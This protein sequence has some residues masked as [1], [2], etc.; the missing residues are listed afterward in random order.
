VRVGAGD[1]E[2]VEQLVA[3]SDEVEPARRPPLRD[4]RGVHGDAERVERAHERL[5]ARRRHGARRGAAVEEQLVRDGDDARRA[6]A[7]EERGAERAQLGR[8]ERRHQRRRHGGGPQRRDGAHVQP[9]QRRRAE[10]GVVGQRVEGGDDQ[11]GDAGVVQPQRHVRRAL[12]VAQD[13]VARAARQQAHH[14]AAQ[15]R[16]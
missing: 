5:V 2:E 10:E 7:G 16:E 14:R 12:R 6:H 9:L 1:D 13:Q 15:V 8:L 11:R 4:A 3:V